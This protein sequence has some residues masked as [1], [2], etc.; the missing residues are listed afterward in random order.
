MGLFDINLGYIENAFEEDRI[1]VDI[2]PKLIEKIT[3]YEPEILFNIEIEDYIGS[4]SYKL[5][6]KLTNGKVLSIF[7]YGDR[8]SGELELKKFKKL[9]E[10]F[11]NGQISKTEPIIYDTGII[12]KFQ[13]ETL[14]YIIMG[15]VT[16][17][18]EWV[19][20]HNKNI[21]KIQYVL[22]YCHWAISGA[23]MN[24][25]NSFSEFCSLPFEKTLQDSI[26]ADTAFKDLVG[27]EDGFSMGEYKLLMFCFWNLF[28]RHNLKHLD[29]HLGNIGV[30]PETV[31]LKMPIFVM[32]DF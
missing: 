10:L 12:S 1:E 27:L 20:K 25:I 22:D 26:G 3:I 30:L 16:P 8:I 17:I 32:F 31:E 7:Q 19:N 14:Y 9:A 6:F 11:K 2:E 23:K 28:K 13:D 29:I 15:Y 24:K 21:E 5:V 18:K 4:G